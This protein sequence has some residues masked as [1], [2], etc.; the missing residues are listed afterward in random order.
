MERLRRK[1]QENSNG[2]NDKGLVNL[3]RVLTT[4]AGQPSETAITGG[5]S[6]VRKAEFV[7][8]LQ[9]VGVTYDSADVD[10]VRCVQ[11]LKGEGLFLLYMLCIGTHSRGDK[12]IVP[13]LA[14]F[15]HV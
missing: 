10:R 4:A 11:D 12:D 6:S 13:P 2:K 7:E 15:S 8:G 3:R 14:V 1:L 5:D 9:R